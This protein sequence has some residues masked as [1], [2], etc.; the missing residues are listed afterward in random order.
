MID[1]ATPDEATQVDVAVADLRDRFPEVGPDHI[2]STVRRLVHQWFLQARITTYVG[3]I[4]GRQAR[5]ELA[6]L[7]T[8]GVDPHHVDQTARSGNS[9][10]VLSARSAANDPGGVPAASSWAASRPTTPSGVNG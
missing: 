8:R 5:A 4:A 7:G 9:A 6:A 10:R 1:T 3:I 2:E